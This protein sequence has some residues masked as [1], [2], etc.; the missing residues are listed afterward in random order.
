MQ[1]SSYTPS[2]RSYREESSIELQKLLQG[3][4]SIK[5]KRVEG[6]T[7]VKEAALLVSSLKE[8]PYPRLQAKSFPSTSKKTSIVTEHSLATTAAAVRLPFKAQLTMPKKTSKMQKLRRQHIK[9]QSLM[10]QRW[11]SFTPQTR[12][13]K[14]GNISKRT[15]NHQPLQ[16]NSN[17]PLKKITPEEAITS[18]ELSK[19]T[20]IA[21]RF[22][23]TPEEDQKL[24]QG[25]EEYGHN[26]KLISEEY[27]NKQ[28]NNKQCLH[29]YMHHIHPK[30]KVGTWSEEEREKLR[31]GVEEFGTASW[32]KIARKLFN[33]ERTGVDCFYEYHNVIDPSLKHEPWTKKEDE[34]L[35]ALVNK[36]G[37]Q[38]TKI[39]AQLPGRS[40]N[41]CNVRYIL[42]LNKKLKKGK[43]SPTEMEQL[44]EGQKIFGKEYS[45]I[46]HISLDGKRSF[47]Q[48][49]SKVRG[50]EDL[51][52]RKSEKK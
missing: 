24:R 52:I 23:W 4:P 31:Q 11:P 5:R 10:R 22:F 35:I 36:L 50:L 28:F 30:R 9:Y 15:V 49:R 39:A 14:I 2:K 46:S 13:N 40:S 29:R 18:K 34:Q 16:I 45:K 43:W 8:S 21:K 12:E 6:F 42:V 47:S 7:Q 25:V 51:R 1:T 38:W 32:A 33:W 3:E 41:R 44:K 19:Q 26:W 48:C 27:L 37:H 17:K 20:N